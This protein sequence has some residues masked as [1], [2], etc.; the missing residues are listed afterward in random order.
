MCLRLPYLVV[1]HSVVILALFVHPMQLVCLS[2]RCVFL[3]SLADG[4]FPARGRLV[5]LGTSP[6]AFLP[7]S[8]AS[9]PIVLPW[10]IGA[11][12]DAVRDRGQL[13]VPELLVELFCSVR[14]SGRCFGVYWLGFLGLR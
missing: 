9:P 11:R 13:Y 4:G 8:M 7:C 5:A 10:L 3:W 12:E 14:C 2:A 1:L 6:F